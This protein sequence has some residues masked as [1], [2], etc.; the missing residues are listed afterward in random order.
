M[1]AF[2][3]AGLA[4]RLYGAN[5]LILDTPAKLA[6]A[7]RQQVITIGGSNLQTARFGRPVNADASIDIQ[8]AKYFFPPPFYPLPPY[9]Y[10]RRASHGSLNFTGSLS[11]NPSN[12]LN[13][14]VGALGA[15]AS[16]YNIFDGNNNLLLLNQPLANLAS[17]QLF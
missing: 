13:L 11:A 10:W 17:N 15:V 6:Q 8:V 9:E 4:V 3:V 16:D 5:P 2:H 12:L 7:V 1:A 14:K